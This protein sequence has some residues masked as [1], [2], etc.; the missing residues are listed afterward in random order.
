MI[1]SDGARRRQAT[2]SDG[3]PGRQLENTAIATG[4]VPISMVGSGE[5]AIWMALASIA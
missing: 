5:P 2:L 3:C 4:R 1:S